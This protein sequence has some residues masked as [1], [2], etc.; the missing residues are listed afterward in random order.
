M[1]NYYIQAFKKYAEFKGVATRPEY[2][3]FALVNFLVMLVL[4]LLGIGLLY[5]AYVFAAF[6]PSLAI[7][8]RRLHDMG[9]SGWHCLW[10]LLP[11][12]G[13]IILLVMLCMP[14]KTSGNKY[15]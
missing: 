6:I 10:A 12:V 9:R 1:F 11:V 13:A 14:T 3:W 8:V 4:D 5:L 15:R 7:C 2:W